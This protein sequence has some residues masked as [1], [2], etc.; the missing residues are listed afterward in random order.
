MS[1]TRTGQSTTAGERR[2]ITGPVHVAW[3]GQPLP[4]CRLDARQRFVD[5]LVVGRLSTDCV[6][7]SV[8]SLGRAGE[9][10]ESG[11]ATSSATLAEHVCP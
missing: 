7:R 6:D 4:A 9:C 3:V 10:F 2:S 1:A 8:R 5:R 11:D